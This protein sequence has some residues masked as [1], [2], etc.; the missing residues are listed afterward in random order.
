[1][2]IAVIVEPLGINVSFLLKLSWSKPTLD[3]TWRYPERFTNNFE[4]RIDAVSST[5]QRNTL[6]F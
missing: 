4:C 2:Q 6:I 1:M 5:G 3:G